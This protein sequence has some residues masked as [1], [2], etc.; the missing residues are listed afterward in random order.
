MFLIAV[1]DKNKCVG[2]GFCERQCQ[3]GAIKVIEGKARVSLF[4]CL[5][6]GRCRSFCKQ[7]AI[8]LKLRSP[9][10][11]SLVCKGRR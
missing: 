11:K 4:K 1:V 3:V 2:C 10:I 6:C 5:G 7:N 9:T 8:H